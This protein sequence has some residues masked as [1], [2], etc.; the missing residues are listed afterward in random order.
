MRARTRSLSPTTTSKRS[1]SGSVADHERSRSLNDRSRR[2]SE[3]PCRPEP[4]RPDSN[5]SAGKCKQSRLPVKIPDKK[6]Q[7]EACECEP[8]LD[9]A[10]SQKP[11]RKRQIKCTNNCKT[12]MCHVC[13]KEKMKKAKQKE[14]RRKLSRGRW[15]YENRS[16]PEVMS[17]NH[18]VTCECEYCCSNTCSEHLRVRNNMQSNDQ[19][20]QTYKHDTYK[21]N[22][23][24][25]GGFESTGDSDVCNFNETEN[26]FRNLFSSLIKSFLERPEPISNT[27]FSWV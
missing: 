20:A 27:I 13:L 5:E 18:P 1:R 23:E 9:K 14:C 15:E 26:Y 22:K 6:C 7:C 21:T 19:E 11:I 10:V 17:R 16:T 2:N 4:I 3:E 12:C 25:T 24:F 8:C